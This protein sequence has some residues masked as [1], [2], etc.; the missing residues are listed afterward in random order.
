M[1][2]NL[3]RW[4]LGG[5]PPREEGVVSKGAKIDGERLTFFQYSG[6]D[7]CQPGRLSRYDTAWNE[8][9]PEPVRRLTADYATRLLTNG[10]GTISGATYAYGRFASGTAIHPN[11]PPHMTR[12][13]RSRCSGAPRRRRARTAR[14]PR[15]IPA[16]GQISQTVT[17]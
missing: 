16:D 17:S 1:P 3:C 8:V 13:V 12:H 7:P 14:E 2:S 6:F 5:R 11:D 4:F 9:M 15:P 10:Y